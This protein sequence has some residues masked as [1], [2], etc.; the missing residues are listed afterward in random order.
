MK[1]FLTCLAVLAL[2]VSALAAEKHE[3]DSLV[4]D[5]RNRFQD[6]Q[7]NPERAIPA[8][9]L[10][11]AQGIVLLNRTKGGLVFAYEN[12]AGVAL[13]RQGKAGRWS[14]AAFMASSEASLGLQAAASS[15]SSWSC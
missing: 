13:V 11:K 2:G 5:L 10:A 12:G 7:R 8:E 1:K 15:R 4:R 14:P 9:T 3:L 6:L